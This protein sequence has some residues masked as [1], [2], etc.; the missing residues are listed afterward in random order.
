MMMLMMDRRVW[1]GEFTFMYGLINLSLSLIYLGDAIPREDFRGF[2]GV[3]F[4]FCHQL[5]PQTSLTTVISGF[6][7]PR[8]HL[9]YPRCC[10]KLHHL[11]ITLRRV[12]L[13]LKRGRGILDKQFEKWSPKTNR[14]LFCYLFSKIFEM[15]GA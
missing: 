12:D 5:H 2:F 11:A 6:S 1:N 4:V 7:T 8:R 10:L 15:T 9:P 13:M 14:N 3:R